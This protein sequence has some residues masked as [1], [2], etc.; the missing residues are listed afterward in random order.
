MA[1]FGIKA[2]CAAL[3]GANGRGGV[4]R[5]PYGLPVAAPRRHSSTAAAAAPKIFDTRRAFVSR[6]VRADQVST[7]DTTD[8][9]L[10]AEVTQTV[11]ARLATTTAASAAAARALDLSVDSELRARLAATIAKVQKGL[12]ERETEVRRG[13]RAARMRQSVSRRVPTG[14]AFC[15]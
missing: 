14:C 4:P 3:G 11:D 2:P 15:G 6:A 1:S 9:Q 5:I 7:V 13:R 10:I 12:L 8:I